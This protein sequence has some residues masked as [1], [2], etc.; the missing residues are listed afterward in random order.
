MRINFVP[1]GDLCLHS[2]PSRPVSDRTFFVSCEYEIAY[3]S[4]LRLFVTASGRCPTHSNTYLPYSKLKYL[5]PQAEMAY[6]GEPCI[7][8]L[9]CRGILEYPKQ[10]IISF[11]TR[12]RVS[13]CLAARISVAKKGR[14]MPASTSTVST[15]LSVPPQSKPHKSRHQFSV[16]GALAF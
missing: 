15:H 3:D 16:L 13:R 8:I 7:A 9:P 2:S 12:H 6:I 10:E 4:S 14:Q 1:I 5:Q 11:L